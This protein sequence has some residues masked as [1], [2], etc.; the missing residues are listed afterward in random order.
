[1]PG[2][3]IARLPPAPMPAPGNARAAMIVLVVG[4]GL[5]GAFLVVSFA[6]GVAAYVALAAEF[7]SGAAAVQWSETTDLVIFLAPLLTAAV[8]YFGRSRMRGAWSMLVVP[9]ALTL[10]FGFLLGKGAAAAMTAYAA[11]HGY[12]ACRMEDVVD[13]NGGRG[14]GPALRSWGYSRLA[15][16]PVVGDPL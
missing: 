12:H 6:F 8:C 14:G 7:R 13:P 3:R 5:V 2:R 9:V 16:P 11:G 1:M 4:L 15:C 10:A